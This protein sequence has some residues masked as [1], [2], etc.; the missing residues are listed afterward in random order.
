[1]C[2]DQIEMDYEFLDDFFVSPDEGQPEFVV[3]TY[4]YLE[5]LCDVV[6]N[7]FFRC[8][9]MMMTWRR[10]MSLIP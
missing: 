9:K 10:S 2:F 5:I 6:Y 3:K 8:K 4:P 7:F 1:M